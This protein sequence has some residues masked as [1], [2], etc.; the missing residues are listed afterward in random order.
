MEKREAIRVKPKEKGEASQRGH[1]GK[2]DMRTRSQ[3]EDISEKWHK[4]SIVRKGKS[5]AKERMRKLCLRSRVNRYPWTRG[6]K[7]GCEFGI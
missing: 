7:K 4:K 3:G 1:E 6:Q 5:S 2:R